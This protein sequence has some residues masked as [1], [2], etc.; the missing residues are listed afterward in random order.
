MLPKVDAAFLNSFIPETTP[1]DIL[2]TPCPSCRDQG[3]AYIPHGDWDWEAERPDELRCKRC[4]ITFPHTDYPEEVVV[5]STWGKPQTFTFMGGE[6]FPVFG[7]PTGR[8]SM[9][10]NIRAQK[11]NWITRY[12][13]T[14]AE[15]YALSGEVAYAET[16]RL[17]LLRFADVYPFWLVHVGYGEYADLEPGVAAASIMNLS[18][19]ELVYPPNVPD[20]RLHTG[21]WSAGR[22]RGVGMEGIWVRGVT[23]AYDLT[24]RAVDAE[25]KPVYSDAERRRIE[26]KVLLESTKLLVGDLKINNKSVGN[27]AAAALVGM[28]CG[29]PELVHFGLDG[30]EK[31]IEEWFLPDGSTPESPAYALMTLHGIYEFGQALRHYS[32]PQGYRSADGVRYDDYQSYRRPAYA[33][34]WEA[35]YHTLQGNLKYPPFG[36]SYLFT[37]LSSLYA[38]LMADHYPE[39]GHYHALLGALLEGDWAKPDAGTAIY[40]AEPG[41]EKR[42]VPPLS[43]E[44]KLLPDLGIGY[45]RTGEDG[46][47]SLLLLNAS[48]MRPHHHRDSLNLYYWKE[49]H[50]L[51][52]DLGY[53]WDH[54]DYSK[55]ARTLAHNTVL[56]DEQDQKHKVMLSWKPQVAYFVVHPQVKAMRAST[57]PFE[58]AERYE[59]AVTYVDHGEGNSYIVDHFW[60]RGGSTHDYVYHGPNREVTLHPLPV[61][62]APKQEQEGLLA[63]V[64]GWF[65]AGD[66]EESIAA[67]S[68]QSRREGPLYDLE[69]VEE[70]SAKGGYRLEWKLNEKLVFSAWNLTGEGE[71]S[72]L[73][74][75]WGQRRH[76]NE[77]RGA[78]LPYLIRRHNGDG[79]GESTFASVFEG[80]APGASFVK[81]VRWLTPDGEPHG[82][83]ALLVETE[84]SRD[85]LV[86]CDKA[87]PVRV[88]TPDGVLETSG[89]LNVLSLSEGKVIFEKVEGGTTPLTLKN[90]SIR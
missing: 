38:E 34:V 43:F 28:V 29:E 26:E 14:L 9:S 61:V 37:G 89:R 71:R 2:F 25:G 15:A 3:L 72:F 90:R 39:N 44:S 63:K 36:D 4:K 47:R 76:R 17:I 51:L 23:K 87:Q 31:T 6:P 74:D 20:R 83:K 45:M 77:D 10:G 82:V 80:H 62:A 21:Y 19:D 86:I 49:G 79:G 41:R 46:R 13:E 88:V 1:G 11:V 66:D 18:E 73:G 7:Y 48:D 85:Y 32:D 27:R 56:I 40:Y 33:R 5:Q 64:A 54:P 75:G 53:L 67:P 57:A 8:P 55:T 84:R 35:M 81:G 42:E 70:I 69:K 50:E 52:S 65:G 22:A 60:V 24:C 59:R 68:R 78:V 12:L 16:A 58:N 30:F